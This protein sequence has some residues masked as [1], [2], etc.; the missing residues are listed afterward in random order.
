MR[1]FRCQDEFVTAFPPVDVHS[2]L[3]AR[4]PRVK[5]VYVPGLV[6]GQVLQ[7]EGEVLALGGDYDVEARHGP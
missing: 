4:V 3:E 1:Q 7:G 2:I 5:L 6:R